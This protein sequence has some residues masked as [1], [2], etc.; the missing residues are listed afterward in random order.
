ML[1]STL[2]FIAKRYSYIYR[3]ESE[4]STSLPSTVQK[5]LPV[6]RGGT[7]SKEESVPVAVPA[8]CGFLQ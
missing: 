4:D 3:V 8:N 7:S 2:K 1:N 6:A 5:L